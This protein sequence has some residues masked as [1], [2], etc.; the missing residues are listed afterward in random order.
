[1]IEAPEAADLFAAN[2]FNFDIPPME[3]RV[4]SSLSVIVERRG[5]AIT[6]SLYL[7]ESYSPSSGA[8]M[9]KIGG[10]VGNGFASMANLRINTVIYVTF[11]HL[12]GG[13]GITGALLVLEALSLEER[14]ASLDFL[15]SMKGSITWWLKRRVA[16]RAR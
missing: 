10:G 11:E 2:A 14:M 4:G 13:S 7:S 9:P 8:G 15:G 1:M 5:M 12:R 3:D 6:S 16:K